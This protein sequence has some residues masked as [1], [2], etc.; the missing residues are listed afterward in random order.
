M[1]GTNTA[2]ICFGG[3]PPGP[4]ADSE[5]WNGTAWTEGNNLNTA[6]GGL[7][8]AGI[9]TSALG[10]GGYV[11]MPSPAVCEAY[12]GTSWTEVG[13]LGT[14][15]SVGASGGAETSNSTAFFGGGNAPGYSNATEEWNDPV[16]SVK[17]VTVS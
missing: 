13:D 8:S 17:T 5:T 2:A 6:R 12:N 15:R 10:F 14:A 16:Y 3:F 9:S 4:T 1:A 11:T 7:G